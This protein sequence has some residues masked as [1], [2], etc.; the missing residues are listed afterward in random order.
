VKAKTKP[1]A[2]A[3]CVTGTVIAI[4]SELDVWVTGAVIAMEERVRF[5]PRMQAASRSKASLPDASKLDERARG[6]ALAG[7]SGN[8]CARVRRT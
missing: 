3:S 8:D 6:A 2:R 5:S 4:S 1:P 7:A